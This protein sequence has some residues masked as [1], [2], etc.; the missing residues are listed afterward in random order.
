MKI[1]ILTYHRSHNYG[2]LLQA[3]ALRKIL[4][5]YGH[6]VTFVDYWPTYHQQRY[7][8][9]SL[10]ILKYLNWKKKLLH[11]IGYVRYY[12]SRKKRYIAFENFITEYIYPYT[13]STDETYDI[14]IYGSDQ[15]W[16]KQRE[17]GN[18][19]P[20]Y[21]GK[22]FKA[23][24]H[25]SFAASMGELPYTEKDKLYVK[26]MLS[27]LDVISVRERELKEFVFNLGYQ[28]RQDLDPTLLLNKDEWINS[29]HIVSRLKEKYILF[30]NLSPNTFDL[31]KVK[32]FASAMKLE[33]KILY[34]G[35]FKHPTPERLTTA[36]PADFLDLL[37]G[38]DYI[39]TSSFHGL[40][41]ALIFNKPFYASFSENS[42]RAASLLEALNLSDRMLATGVSIP[43]NDKTIDWLMV[44]K[45][46]TNLRANTLQFIEN[47]LLKDNHEN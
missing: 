16:R 12:N 18:Y 21:F 11:I 4:S 42:G 46:L 15:I 3:Y 5:N 10:S 37:Y 2:A 36:G 47:D 24:R 43:K 19:N 8:L 40:A 13:S 32:D 33:V 41:F 29:L 44:N 23:S 25:I 45:K 30:Y 35:A 34:S 14:L 6:E 22:I 1:G 27:N 17:I 7:A 28:C 9:F 38:A 26:K 31:Q 20:A 39:L